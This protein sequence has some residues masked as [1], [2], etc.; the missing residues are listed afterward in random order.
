MTEWI[1]I[2]IVIVLAGAVSAGLLSLSYFIGLKRPSAEKLRPYECGV[3]PVGSANERHS[4]RFYLMGMLF[5]LFDIEVVF[6]Y[7]WA[8]VYHQLGLFGLVEMMIFIAILVLGYIYAWKM[9]ALEWQ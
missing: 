9:G 6:L 2:L 4:V 8:T 3:P 1:P 5:I 7:P